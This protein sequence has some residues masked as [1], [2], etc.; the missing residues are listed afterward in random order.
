MSGALRIIQ[1][2]KIRKS[3]DSRVQHFLLETGLLRHSQFESFSYTLHMKVMSHVK[4]Y[5][6][7]LSTMLSS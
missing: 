6:V 5:N 2:V 7:K 3:K 1:F 4:S